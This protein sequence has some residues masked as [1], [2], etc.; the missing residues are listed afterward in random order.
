MTI[1]R[2]IIVLSLPLTALAAEIDMDDLYFSSQNVVLSAQEKAALGLAVKEQ[3][4]HAL[5]PFAGS[6]GSVRFIYGAARPRLV[7]AVLQICDVELQPGETV[8]SINLGDTARWLVE[9]ALTGTGDS[10]I[11][12][13]MIKPLDVGLNTSLVVTTDR[14][15]YH[16]QLRSHRTQ[17]IPHV[18][19]SYPEETMKSWQQLK[20]KEQQQ[21]QQ[22]TLPD[23]GEYLSDLDFNYH[24]EGD[25]PWKPLRV[26]N[27]GR[28]TI[29]EMPTAMSQ[30]EAP[31]L[32]VISRE[33]GLFTDEEAVMVNYRVQGHRYI[34]DTIIDNAI[35]ITGISSQQQ[36]VT[37]RRREGQ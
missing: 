12:H 22:N 9:P 34:V 6:D 24:L 8:Q 13:L 28:K 10:Q 2:L 19:F 27:D 5:K 4:P 29:L 23:T 7:C 16:L 11:Q 35:L 17:F 21:Q 33:G 20:V 31:S 32:L 37:I 14:R 3:A 36:R 1:Y 26:Y 18:T 15:T 25:A 30:T